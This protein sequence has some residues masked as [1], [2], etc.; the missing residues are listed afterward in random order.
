MPQNVADHFGM[1]DYVRE[2]GL[3]FSEREIDL[4]DAQDITDMRTGYDPVEA[5]AS[6]SPCTGSEIFGLSRINFT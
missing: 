2:S 6:R 5:K 3:K 4:H 1:S